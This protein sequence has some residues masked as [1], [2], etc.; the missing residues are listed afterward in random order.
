MGFLTVKTETYTW[1]ESLAFQD[2]IKQNGLLQLLKLWKINVNV[3]KKLQD[4]KWGEEL[5]YHVFSIKDEEKVAQIYAEGF[6]ATENKLVE[7][8]DF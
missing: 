4:L 5:E 1:E 8:F 2:I 6:L 3:Q 7:G